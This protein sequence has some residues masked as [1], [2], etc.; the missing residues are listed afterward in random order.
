MHT[1]PPM[2]EGVDY[3]FYGNTPQLNSERRTIP[4]MCPQRL[5]NPLHCDLLIN[6]GSNDFR[7]QPEIKMGK[8]FFLTQIS[9]P[10][11]ISLADIAGCSIK[12]LKFISF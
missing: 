9:A 12:F 5:R 6:D 7:L 3:S 10:Y 1:L 8:D 2:M 11:F 4:S